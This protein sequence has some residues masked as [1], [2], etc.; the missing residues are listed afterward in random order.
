[1]ELLAYFACVCVIF[2]SQ[3]PYFCCRLQSCPINYGRFLTCCHEPP[4]FTFV[5]LCSIPFAIEKALVVIDGD[6]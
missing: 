3:A 2:L 6:V 5:D 4:F 1:M